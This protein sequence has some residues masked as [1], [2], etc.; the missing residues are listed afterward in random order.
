MRPLTI[1]IDDGES[2]ITYVA[3]ADEDENGLHTLSA[4]DENGDEVER[5][6][7]LGWASCRAIIE[8]T[9]Q[10]KYEEALWGE[11]AADG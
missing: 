5:W 6:G 11:E 2:H 8:Q 4:L 1:R 7:N 9:I 3:T 10:A